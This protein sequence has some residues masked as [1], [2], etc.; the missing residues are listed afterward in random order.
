M[1]RR[2]KERRRRC[3]GASAAVLL[4]FLTGCTVSSGIVT[5]I[6]VSDDT[7]VVTKCDD[8]VQF[9]TVMAQSNCHTETVSGTLK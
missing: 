6:N 9:Y 8:V 5:D 1:S 2:P 4:L 7:L 3:L